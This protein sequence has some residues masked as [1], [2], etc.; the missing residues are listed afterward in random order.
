MK[1]DIEKAIKHIR[2]QL[3]KSTDEKE[4]AQLREALKNLKKL[5]SEE[6]KSA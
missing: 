5:K 1:T 4:K 6:K 3:Q 2:S